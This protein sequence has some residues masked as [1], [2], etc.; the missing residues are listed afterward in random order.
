M[1]FQVELVTVAV[2]KPSALPFVD[3]AGVEITRDQGS[4]PKSIFGQHT[5]LDGQIGRSSFG[6]P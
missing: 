3:G 4:F 1:N 2:E 5:R 6:A